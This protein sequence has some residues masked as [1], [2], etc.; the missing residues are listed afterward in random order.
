MRATEVIPYAAKRLDVMTSSFNSIQPR[1]MKNMPFSILSTLQVAFFFLEY[2]S[3]AD[4]VDDQCG[5]RRRRFAI[6]YQSVTLGTTLSRS[7]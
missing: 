7:F 2:T 1:V 3:R 5:R 4:L 6:S